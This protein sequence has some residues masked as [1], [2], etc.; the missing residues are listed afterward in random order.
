MII[1]FSNLFLNIILFFYFIYFNCFNFNI[2]SKK[3]DFI[4]TVKHFLKVPI[5]NNT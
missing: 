1:D 5:Y 2:C 4:S 3:I